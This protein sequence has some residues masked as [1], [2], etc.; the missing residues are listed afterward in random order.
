ME[1]TTKEMTIANKIT[2]NVF[3]MNKYIKVIRNNNILA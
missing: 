1:Y 3:I 2:R